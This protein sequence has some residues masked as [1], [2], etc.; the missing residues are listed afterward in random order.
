LPT[1]SQFKAL[2]ARTDVT[3][4]EQLYLI[5]LFLGQPSKVQSIR[6]AGMALGLRP[7]K[8]WNISQILARTNGH[9]I[10]TKQGW[11]LSDHGKAH[12]ATKGIVAVDAEKVHPIAEKLRKQ[13]G[14]AK[15][16]DAAAFVEEAI[17]CFE[18]GFYRAAIVLSWIG[19]VAVLHDHVIK[20]M[21]SNFN[22]EAKRRDQKWRDA[23]S[24]DDLGRMKEG[25]F[26]DILE[27]LSA[28]G[29]NVK[30]ELKNC[31]D[32]RNGC[33][34][35]NSLKIGESTVAHHLEILLLNVFAKF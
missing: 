17:R 24:P 7:I 4:A 10:L 34:H 9:A 27:T 30:A 11:E 25:E 8:N 14:A 1:E 13:L 15:S 23:K 32:R 6:D 12:L 16:V 21:L 28:I 29:K 18:N 31:L 26:L 3:R 20:N 22:T 2:L 35:P 33:G 19:A 5:L